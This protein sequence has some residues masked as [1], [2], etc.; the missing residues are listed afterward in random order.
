MASMLQNNVAWNEKRLLAYIV[1][2]EDFVFI[3]D[4]VILDY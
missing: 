1:G 2:T 4:V 3:M